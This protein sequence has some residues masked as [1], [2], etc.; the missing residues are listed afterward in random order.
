LEDDLESKLKCTWP[1]CTQ[2]NV[3]F[4]FDIRRTFECC[5]WSNPQY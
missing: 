2:F 3:I 4:S 1:H 5:V